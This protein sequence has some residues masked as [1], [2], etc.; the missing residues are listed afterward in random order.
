MGKRSFLGEMLE[1][2]QITVVEYI[3]RLGLL[4]MTFRQEHHGH[5]LLEGQY[6]NFVFFAPCLWVNSS[7]FTE[8]GAT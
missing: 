6:Q 3:N 4:N 2:I 7:A 8:T 1:D 5:T